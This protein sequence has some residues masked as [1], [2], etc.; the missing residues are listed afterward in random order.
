MH[1]H[2]FCVGFQNHGKMLQFLRRGFKGECSCF[3]SF[4]VV[5]FYDALVRRKHSPRLYIVA[6]LAQGA[7]LKH[8]FLLLLLILILLLLVFGFLFLVRAYLRRTYFSVV[9]RIYI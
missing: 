7:H 5:Q 6:M 8:I 4:V 1:K 9:K 2:G 3:E